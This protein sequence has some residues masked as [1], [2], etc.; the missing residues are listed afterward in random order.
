MSTSD[1]NPIVRN[2]PVA[3][4]VDSPYQIRHIAG[5]SE[6]DAALL[7]L[8]ANIKQHGLINPITVRPVPG[9]DKYECVAGH[10]RLEAVRMNDAE[11][12]PAVFADGM[13]DEEAEEMCVS[14]NLFR[15]DLSPME[16][17]DTVI[18]LLKRRTIEAVAKLYQK[19]ER[20]VYRR[21][22]LDKLSTTSKV[23]ARLYKWPAAFC[24]ALAQHNHPD[25][26][27]LIRNAA[28][29][30]GIDM[31]KAIDG[32][33]DKE[34]S[35]FFA[36]ELPALTEAEAVVAPRPAKK[37]RK[38]AKKASPAAP[39]AEPEA[40][41]EE[42]EDNAPA[43]KLGGK[44]KPEKDDE[45]DADIRRVYELLRVVENPLAK[46]KGGRWSMAKLL[47]SPDWVNP[48]DSDPLTALD[49]LWDRMRT[50]LM[51]RIANNEIQ[52]VDV[53]NTLNKIN[54]IEPISETENNEN[55]SEAAN[56]PD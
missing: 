35:P 30:L 1:N 11:E 28:I 38:T 7:E 34:V 49:T 33:A 15:L 5:T 31:T 29:K 17:A 48:L 10:R 13:G 12:I 51:R 22:E 46:L 50:S 16:E 47:T 27:A 53:E 37:P 40:E 25:Q 39:K 9:S 19:S 21:M 4:I 55:E 26:E 20:W 52:A 54:H 32:L 2:I 6:L 44:A 8:A 3:D 36:G 56:E 24:E 14:E 23:V 41:P 42:E 45:C 43:A 18:K